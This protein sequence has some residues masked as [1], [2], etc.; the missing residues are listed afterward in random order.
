LSCGCSTFLKLLL[1]FHFSSLF[2]SLLFFIVDGDCVAYT[3]TALVISAPCKD[4]AIF[5]TGEG[6]VL[7]TNDLEDLNLLELLYQSW[8]RGRR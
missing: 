5:S 4:S 7:S 6:V 8:G 1:F 3:D 2:K